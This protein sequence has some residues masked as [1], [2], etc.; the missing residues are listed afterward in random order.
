VAALTEEEIF[1]TVSLIQSS[2]GKALAIRC[3]VSN[4]AQ[5]KNLI[6][7]TLKKSWANRCSG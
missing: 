3:D 2:G 5:I 4:E 1:F 6:D 7:T